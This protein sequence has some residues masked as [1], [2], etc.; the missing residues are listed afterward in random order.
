MELKVGYRLKSPAFYMDKMSPMELKESSQ[1]G[2]TSC[3]V[4]TKCLDI[5]I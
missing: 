2:H 3:P 4:L 5:S 1:Q